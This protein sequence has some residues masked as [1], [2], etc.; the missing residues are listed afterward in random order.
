[1]LANDKKEQ[2]ISDW[3]ESQYIQSVNFNNEQNNKANFSEEFKLF[4]KNSNF[5]KKAQNGHFKFPIT[6]IKRIESFLYLKT[7]Y[8]LDP[9]GYTCGVLWSEIGSS[10]NNTQSHFAYVYWKKN[11]DLITNPLLQFPE[12]IS[13]SPTFDSRDGEYRKRFIRY[14]TFISTYEMYSDQLS[15]FEEV[16]FDIISNKKLALH[17]TFFPYDEKLSNDYKDSRLL[18]K[19][20]SYSLALDLWEFYTGL[21]L[22]HTNIKYRKTI[23]RIGNDYPELIT[24]SKQF[25]TME[26]ISDNKMTLHFE[27]LDFITE[28]KCGQKLIPL[29]YN[30]IMNIED[31]NLSAWREININQLMSDLVINYITP[32]FPLY[33]DWAYIFDSDL[34]LFEN[35]AMHNKY[36]ISDICEHTINKLREARDQIQT[37]DATIDATI[38]NLPDKEYSQSPII[39]ELKHISIKGDSIK[40]GNTGGNAISSEHDIAKTEFMKSIIN[41]GVMPNY[42][43]KEYNARLYEDIEYA[44]SNLILSKISLLNIIEDVGWTLASVNNYITKS[45]VHPTVIRELMTNKDVSFHYIFNYLYAAYAMHTKAH[46]VHSDIHS[47]NLTINVWGSVLSDK[48]SHLFIEPN[49]FEKFYK[50]ATV[51]YAT[52]IDNS[53]IYLFPATGINATIIDF[54]RAIIGPGLSHKLEEGGRGPQY[55]TNFYRDQVNKILA[56]FNRYAPSYVQQNQEPIKAAIIANFELIYPVLC[57]IDCMAIGGCLINFF[58]SILDCENKHEINIKNSVISNVLGGKSKK[59]KAKNMFDVMKSKKNK[60]NSTKIKKLAQKLEKFIPIELISGAD[61]ER[62]KKIQSFIL[63]KK[64]AQSIES[65]SR[66]LLIKGLSTIVDYIKG[67]INELPKIQSPAKVIINKLF[68]EYAFSEKTDYSSYDIVDGYNYNNDIKYN[69]NNYKQFP[70]WANIENITKNLNGYNINNIFPF[71]LETFLENKHKKKI[72]TDIISE[73]TKA[74]TEKLHGNPMYKDSSWID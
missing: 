62:E 67:D 25:A 60:L 2:N 71:G 32:S 39:A 35:D 21:L 11:S 72:Y 7:K 18:L 63:S 31:Y 19:V 9:D 51:V 56:A 70:A 10:K 41:N 34:T 36:A 20:F 28:I 57:C 6:G 54:S 42:S 74:D 46:I 49:S 69:G 73:K 23:L 64:L 8:S 14:D 48:D 44:H 12:Y 40:G 65:T 38:D 52:G 50:R 59:A 66:E 68:P 45:L 43:T 13:I 47:N 61:E 1:M 4:I 37:I 29:Y 3:F 30:E 15:K 58:D 33:G 5:P 22:D 55:A 27:N 53:D 16:I 24:L 17:L 26:N